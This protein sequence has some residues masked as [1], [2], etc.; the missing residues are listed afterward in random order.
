V[1]N[2]LPDADERRAER[3]WAEALDAWEVWV[4]HASDV[5]AGLAPS[6]PVPPALPL[7]GPPPPSLVLR[8]H[9]LLDTIEQFRTKGSARLNGEVRAGFAYSNAPR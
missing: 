7:T 3:D 6:L 4:G 1:T 8:A 2:P 9:V 5:I